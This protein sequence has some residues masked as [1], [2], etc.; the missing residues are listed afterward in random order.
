M[1]NVYL[2]RWLGVTLC[3]FSLQANKLYGCHHKILLKITGYRHI[4]DFEKKFQIFFGP[5]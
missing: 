4:L 3:I 5:V 1:P 2:V